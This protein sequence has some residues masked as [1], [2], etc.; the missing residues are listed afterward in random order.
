MKNQSN[1]IV[2]PTDV[3]NK[4]VEGVNALAAKGIE[5][6]LTYLPEPIQGFA[7]PVFT[8][9]MAAFMN[10]IGIPG[11][12]AEPSDTEKILAE[13]DKIKTALSELRGP[14]DKVQSSIDML[15]KLVEKESER[16]IQASK[17]QQYILAKKRIDTKW[18]LILGNVKS[19]SKATV[20]GDKAKMKTALKLYYTQTI[21]FAKE[22]IDDMNAMEVAVLRMFDERESLF[23][24]MTN[25]SIVRT[26]E[27]ILAKAR[28]IYNN[29]DGITYLK[30]ESPE[31]W[32]KLLDGPCGQAIQN[33][34]KYSMQGKHI[35]NNWY[36]DNW[37]AYMSKIK[38]IIEKEMINSPLSV[39][40]SEINMM[41]SKSLMVLA[42]IYGEDEG[43]AEAAN[44]VIDVM[45]RIKE[46]ANSNAKRYV[47]TMYAW[48]S[49]TGKWAQ[50]AD[51]KYPPAP[52]LN[53]LFGNW[54]NQW[55]NTGTNL[56]LPG[57]YVA[58]NGN[59]YPC[60]VYYN[61][62][63]KMESAEKIWKGDYT[64]G[65][66]MAYYCDGNK[67][68]FK[69]ISQNLGENVPMWFKKAMKYKEVAIDTA[70]KFISQ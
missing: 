34:A 26:Q 57:T 33:P 60:S 3:K 7:G 27:A 35:T 59:Y 25:L 37:F 5:K 49:N 69:M 15:A 1:S 53:T 14:L 40:F 12:E 39:F 43:L 46:N 31:I 51:K 54:A 23:D 6:A 67:L 16:I 64:P 28:G 32:Q 41:A 13:L 36:G 8:K 63:N 44:E 45:N 29:T 30:K 58:E 50:P 11:V 17:Y 10:V 68:A 61:T 4:L 21:N 42:I 24:R 48:V 65:L 38:P 66:M 20:E 56:S 52:D 2:D 18:K 62:P 70:T 47:D 9:G 55:I 19:I 22:V